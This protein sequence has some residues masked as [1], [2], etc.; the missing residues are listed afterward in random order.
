MNAHI[1]LNLLIELRKRDLI[2]EF[3]KF[4]RSTNDRFYLSHD[5]KTTLKSL[6]CREN[7][8]IFVIYTRLYYGRQYITLPKSVNH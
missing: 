4:Y 3:N 5:P 1:L 6:F 7:A 2:N 8:K